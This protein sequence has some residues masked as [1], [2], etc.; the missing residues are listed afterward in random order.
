MTIKSPGSEIGFS[1]VNTE[2][3]VQPS[4]PTSLNF[5][6]EKIKQSQRTAQPQLGAFYGLAYYQRNTDGNCS[7]ANINNCNCNCGNINCSATANCQGISIPNCDK[8]EFLQANC[9]CLP[10]NFSY[11]CISNQNC[12]SYNCNCSKII[13]TKL[14]DLGLLPKDIF[15]ADQAFG[16][17]LIKN[18]PDIYNGY[19]AWAQIVVDWMS[20]KGPKMMPW[21]TDKEFS[22]SAKVWSTNWAKDIAT[23][24][25]NWMACKMGIGNKSSKTGLVL[26]IIGTPLCKVIGTWQRIVGKSKKP[27]GFFAG[28]SL[29]A[30]FAVLKLVATIGKAIEK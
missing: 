12:F 21:M 26:M 30:I 19:V 15:E 5:L 28:L 23:P 7:N 10:P 6:H 25:A 17:E 20:G 4:T 2:I 1:D 16:T 9:N 13:C 24:W 27:A 29:I 3:G 11:N 18:H 14:Y 8:Q 22:N